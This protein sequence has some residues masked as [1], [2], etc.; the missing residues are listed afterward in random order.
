MSESPVKQGEIAVE[1]RHLDLVYARVATLRSEA[2]EMR[3]QGYQLAH[4]AGVEADFEAAQM[5]HERDVMVHHANRLLHALETEHSDLVFGRLDLAEGTM[6][7]VGRL[8]VSDDQSRS[9]VTDW[10]APA[11][12][13]FYQATAQEP[14]GVLRRRVIRCSGEIVK[15]IDD[16]PL[17]PDAIPDGM[18]VV[19]EGALM[20][21]LGRAR[22]E[23]M[24]D[25]VAT[26][27][28]EQDMAI[29][30]PLKGV[31]QITGGP[32][33][34]KT[35]VALHRVAFLLYSERHR[36]GKYGVLVIGPSPHF[37]NYI[38]RVLPS[39]GETAAELRA[40]GEL[41]D[42]VRASYTDPAPVAA[43][44]GSL[45]MRRV[46]RKLVRQT[47]PDAPAELKL[48][49]RGE[50]LRLNQ[51]DLTK[52]RREVHRRGKP[53][54]RSRMVAADV[55]L[56]ALWKKASQYADGKYKPVRDDLI[57]EIGERIEFHR[58]LVAW[59]P[60]LYPT[61]MLGWL[62]DRAQLRSMARDVLSLA[63]IDL[64]SEAW[65]KADD[66]ISVAD[67]A[68]LDELYAMIGP[69]PTPRSWRKQN[70]K[71]SRQGDAD[72][73]HIVVD[74]VQDVSPM[75]WRMIGRRGTY[76]T[77][78]IVGDPVQT[79]WPNP[80]EAEEARM[81]ALG[82]QRR[83]QHFTLRTNYRNSEEIFGLAAK[84]IRPLATDDQL[85]HAV[86]STGVQPIVS[87][88][89]PKD[90]PTV[91]HKAAIDLIGQ[92]DGTI[93]VIT[94]M[95]RVAEVREWLAEIDDDRVRVVGSLDSKGLEYDATIV[96]EPTA[97]IDESP[98]GRRTLYVAM[99][100]ATQR[101]TVIASDQ[102]WL[103]AD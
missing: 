32:G 2:R 61:E 71:R 21:A 95:D 51:E 24:H 64:L 38:S 70:Q 10:R 63:E 25:I 83:H 34:G 59:W 100:R 35:A 3:E 66:R 41:V 80:D 33:T 98:T 26:I 88:V 74:E 27:Q 93:G 52:A 69:A 28:R 44:K 96:L 31:T 15:D 17:T 14:M 84:V 94:V 23:N 16:E 40:L 99:T 7:H 82:D 1:Q 102:D 48:F 42:G 68:L 50:V 58:F 92:V 77:W 9:L 11:A 73:S 45:R 12:S 85:P 62:A 13:A 78:T 47:P 19:G 79:S 91:T 6:M 97:M 49:Y 101:M 39:M 36:L 46:L 43:V 18:Q 89:D 54:N 55:L 86:R 8:G 22:S 4:G 20:A 67:V 103:P 75:Q 81:Q 37:T 65:Q 29:R 87:I 90:L 30:A 76:S 5:L 60:P 53:A 56:D 57:T 72:Y